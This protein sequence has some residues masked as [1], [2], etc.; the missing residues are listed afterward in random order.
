MTYHPTE[1]KRQE[2]NLRYE[3]ILEL[4]AM[5]LSYKEIAEKVD[6]TPQRVAQVVRNFGSPRDRDRMERRRQESLR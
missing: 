6:R 3:W 4:Y 2:L 1:A 5:G